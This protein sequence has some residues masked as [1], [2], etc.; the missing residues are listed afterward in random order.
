MWQELETQNQENPSCGDPSREGRKGEIYETRGSD[1]SKMERGQ[2]TIPSVLLVAAEASASD[3]CILQRRTIVRRRRRQRELLAQH[4]RRG[5]SASW[6]S[7]ELL[8]KGRRMKGP[9]AP[10][11]LKPPFGQNGETVAGMNA[12]LALARLCTASWMCT[13]GSYHLRVIAMNR[14]K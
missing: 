12:G 7:M 9:S 6:H 3:Y 1:K 4:P 10:G 13:L 11:C 5:C 14:C 8:I 2:L